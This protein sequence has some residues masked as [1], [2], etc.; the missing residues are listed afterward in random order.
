ME[1]ELGLL[2]FE[3]TTREMTVLVLIAVFRGF[4]PYDLKDPQRRQ[5]TQVEGEV[6]IKGLARNPLSEKPSS[7]VPEGG[8]PSGVCGCGC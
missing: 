3:K 7:M 4:V 1:V 8:G 6:T 2:A 5:Q